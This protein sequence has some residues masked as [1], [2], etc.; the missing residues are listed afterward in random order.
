ME[1]VLGDL[2]MSVALVFI[3]DLCIFSSSVDEGL[4][5]L[6][7]VFEKL[8]GANMK[9]RPSKCKLLQVQVE[10]LGSVVSE[11][12]I[13]VAKRIIDAVVDFKTPT[14]PKG[15][16]RF[17][18][19]ANFYREH[20]N[21]FAE[22]MHPLVRLTRKDV[23]WGW[24]QEC[25][26]AFARMKECLISAP[27][28]N[29]VNFDLPLVLACDASAVGLGCILSN[30]DEQGRQL[31]IAYGSKTLKG[32]ELN[33]TVTEKELFSIF[34]FVRKFKHYL[35]GRKFIVQ[36]DH[37]ALKYIT[38]ARDS[39]G[40]I[41]RMLNFLQGFDFEIHHIPGAKMEEI[42]PDILSRSMLPLDQD[43]LA[44]KM[45][46]PVLRL[47]HN[48][49]PFLSSWFSIESPRPNFFDQSNNL[50]IEV[51]TLGY[52][53]PE[54]DRA[55]AVTAKEEKLYGS[56]KKIIKQS[57]NEDKLNVASSPPPPTTPR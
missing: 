14:D 29:F 37:H 8:R 34:T 52:D 24:T 11:N 51:E 10:Y 4:V 39:T 44:R 2:H 5:R 31:L 27:V 46:R 19:L 17:A 28:R 15:I 26:R 40:K 33:W 9:L 6:R 1:E 25:E 41:T 3:D 16:M 20:I 57:H 48:F 30:L 18:G 54:S 38:G 36:S 32:P 12:G 13:A 45:E 43:T 23:K 49:S 22:I 50:R 7:A 35:G 56:L 21:G 55:K 53:D 42:G 47:N